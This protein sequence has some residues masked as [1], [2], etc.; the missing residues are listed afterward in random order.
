VGLVAIFLAVFLLPLTLHLLEG[1][2]VAVVLLVNRLRTFKLEVLELL[3]REAQAEMLLMGQL[4][5]ELVVAV[6]VRDRMEPLA[7]LLGSVVLVV[8]GC[9]LQLQAL[10]SQEAVAAVA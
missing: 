8:T 2:A 4:R 7:H 5:F 3:D 9:H 10:Q 6:A 1:R